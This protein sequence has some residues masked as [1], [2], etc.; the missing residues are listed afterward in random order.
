[1]QWPKRRRRYAKKDEKRDCPAK[2]DQSEARQYEGVKPRSQGDEDQNNAIEKRDTYRGELTQYKIW[3]ADPAR[4]Y[5]QQK[6]KYEGGKAEIDHDRT[7]QKGRRHVRGRD[8]GQ[9]RI[10]LRQLCE[11]PPQ[12]SAKSQRPGQEGQPVRRCQED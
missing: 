6:A 11:P 1:M 5:R 8:P 2:R 10:Q 4:E 12:Q 3:K 7:V 9:P